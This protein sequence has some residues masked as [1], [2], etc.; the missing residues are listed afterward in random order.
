M[1]AKDAV[2]NTYTGTAINALNEELQEAATIQMD[3]VFATTNM[4]SI[5]LSTTSAGAGSFEFG[6]IQTTGTHVVLRAG[7]GDARLRLVVIRQH[8]RSGG[9]TT[10]EVRC[11]RRITDAAHLFGRRRSDDAGRR[12]GPPR[13]LAGVVQRASSRRTRR[14]R[15]RGAR[16]RAAPGAHTTSPPAEGERRRRRDRAR[17]DTA[18][19]QPS[20]ARVH[21]AQSVHRRH[22][23]PPRSSRRSD[24]IGASRRRSSDAISNASCANA[25]VAKPRGSLV[26]R[27]AG[28]RVQLLVRSERGRTHVVALCAPALRERVERA[29]AHARFALA[30]RGVHAEAA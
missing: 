24:P 11:A 19:P 30:A 23:G 22:T 17:P 27:T 25:P 7:D 8:R 28:G 12:D 1:T 29:L 20:S 9:V 13:A 5:V 2:G 16:R 10:L 15:D 14:S 6:P 18:S 4:T 26:V 21:V 3:S